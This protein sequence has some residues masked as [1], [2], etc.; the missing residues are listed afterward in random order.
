[1]LVLAIDTCDA[2]GSV[3]IL[4]DGEVV[5]TIAHPTGEGYSSWLQ[6]TVDQLLGVAGAKL[7]DVELFAVATGP[8]SFT[9][10]RIGLTTVKAWGEVFGR[11]IA[12]MSRLEVLAG[13]GR[14][15]APFVASFIDAQ[16]GQV[17]GALYKRDGV[18]L[19]LCRDEAVS[20]GADFLAEVL[21]ETGSAAVEW[22]TTD[23]AVME[24]LI[25][26]RERAPQARS[27][28]EVSP[29]L[30]PLIGKLGL[31]KALRG[32]VRDALSLD[33]NY[34]RR[35]YIEVAAKPAHDG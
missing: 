7:A 16:R 26:W 2:K 27:V 11:P 1:M 18:E 21:G 13:Q 22:V 33:A 35:S 5:E 9:G 17:F 15:N 20:G 23:V 3:A 25:E 10:V 12:A 8:G 24:S 29:V 30:A 28:L 6:P 31:Q 34:V 32:Q 4:R 19:A 14:S